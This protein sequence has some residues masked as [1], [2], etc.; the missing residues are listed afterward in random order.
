M[1]F[2]RETQINYYYYYHDYRRAM[3]IDK[4]G[5]SDRIIDYKI[6]RQK[7]IEQELDYKFIWTDDDKGDFDILG[8]IN[9]IFIHTKQSFNQLTKQLT[10]ESWIDKVSMRLLELEFKSDNMTKSKSIKHI[11]KKDIIRLWVK[12]PDFTKSMLH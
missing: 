11:V 7:A 2:V 10:K 1:Y 8:V 3:E 5:H 4:S 6:Q 12:S 9:E